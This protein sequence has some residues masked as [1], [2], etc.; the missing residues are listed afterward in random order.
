MT[1]NSIASPVPSVRVR[2][3]SLPQ[4]FPSLA[5]SVSIT[6]CSQRRLRTVRLV[7]VSPFGRTPSTSAAL[8]PLHRSRWFC[9]YKKDGKSLHIV[10]DLQPLNAITIK[11]S[12]Q[13]PN[14]ELLAES[15]G[16]YSCYATFD[17]FVRFDQC[18]LDAESCDLTTFQ[19]LLGTFRLTSIPMGYM[20]SMQIQHGDLTFILQDEIL[21]VTKPFVHDCPYKRPENTLQV[22]RQNV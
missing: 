5:G 2:V 17:L 1:V 19:T 22:S 15:F 12:A 21:H 7:Q 11:D 20:N 8:K 18:H 10:H 9:I 6:L 13:P 16:G 3:R 14:V 4:S